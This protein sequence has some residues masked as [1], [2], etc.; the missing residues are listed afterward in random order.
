MRIDILS[1]FPSFFEGPFDVSILKRARQKGLLDLRLIDIRDFA[2][3]RHRKVDDRPWGGGPG[4]VMLPG[5]IIDAIRSIKEKESWV[6]FLSPQGTKLDAAR[7]RAFAG[8][9]HLILL[10]GHYEGVDER[11]LQVVDEVV[12][13]GDYVL[14]SGC[15]AA[16]VFVDVVARFIPGVLGNSQAADQDSFEEEGR[17]DAPQYT[18]PDEFEGMCIPPIL[19][20]GH[21]AKI[22]SWRKQQ[23]YEKTCMIRPDLIGD[24]HNGEQTYDSMQRD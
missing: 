16:I 23:A 2:K 12:S 1:L 5:P 3:D 6:I 13:I 7:G 14:T 10:C 8:K 20:T 9:S 11:V 24:L 18:G 15:P 4:M 19:K 17:F 22:A 21:H